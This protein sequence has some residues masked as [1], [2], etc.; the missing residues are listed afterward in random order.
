MNLMSQAKVLLALVEK[1]SLTGKDLAERVRLTKA[2]LIRVLRVLTVR[3]LVSC[4]DDFEARRGLTGG[5][6]THAAWSLTCDVEA[7]TMRQALNA[8]EFEGSGPNVFR[9]VGAIK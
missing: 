5:R 3:D 7:L 2:G 6:Y 4:Q 1:G 9:A 8:L